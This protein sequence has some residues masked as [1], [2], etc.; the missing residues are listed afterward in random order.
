[1]ARV[2]E[3]IP[4]LWLNRQGFLTMRGLK[5]W[6]GHGELDLVGYHPHERVGVHVE[7]SASPKLSGFLGGETAARIRKGVDAYVRKKYRRD[8]VKTV[9]EATC[10]T[11]T[12]WKCILAHGEL[13]REEEVRRALRYNT[14]SPHLSPESAR[15]IEDIVSAAYERLK[16][17]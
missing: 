5:T 7:V 14:S 12:I 17:R 15:A 9:R 10:P 4:E 3:T 11:E 13:K 6:T 2:A 16:D 1:M 8:N